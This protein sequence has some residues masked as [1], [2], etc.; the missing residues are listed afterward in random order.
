[1][2]RITA[3]FLNI[4]KADIA[5]GRVSSELPGVVHSITYTTNPDHFWH[6]DSFYEPIIP[7]QTMLP[8]TSYMGVSAAPAYIP[9]F[10]G[11]DS[12]LL[13]EGDELQSREATLEVKMEDDAP[14][15]DAMDILINQGAYSLESED[16]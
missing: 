13:H 6:T 8:M 1:M 5:A 4:E 7:A 3:Q 15:S 11:S 12:Y 14:I 10:H 16:L 9:E 2:K